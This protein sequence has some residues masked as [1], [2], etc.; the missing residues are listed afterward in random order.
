MDFTLYPLQSRLPIVPSNGIPS[1]TEGVDG[2]VRLDVS[3]G[4]QYFK[5]AGYGWVTIFTPGG[6]GGGGGINWGGGTPRPAS[7]TVYQMFF[8]TNLVPPQPIW[9]TN[10]APITWVNSAGA[11]V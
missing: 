9:C 1:N 8:D 4:A 5:Q 7:P 10:I 2:E 3:T 11:Q 6:G